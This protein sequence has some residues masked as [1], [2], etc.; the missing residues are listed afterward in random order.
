MPFLP[1]SA[2]FPPPSPGM[3][4]RPPGRGRDQYQLTDWECDQAEQG[5]P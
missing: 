4:F 3:P 2:G 5:V 1:T